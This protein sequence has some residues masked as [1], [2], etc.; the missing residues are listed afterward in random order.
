MDEKIDFTPKDIR[1][2]LEEL[3][4]FIPYF[5]ERVN[6]T[7]KFQYFD[8]EKDQLVDYEGY[9]EK[10]RA[11]KFPDPMYDKTFAGFKHIFIEKIS[12]KLKP[13]L[14]PSLQKPEGEYTPQE[15]FL[16]VLF[17]LRRDIVHERLCTGHTASCMKA[18]VYLKEL[19][20]LQGMLDGKIKTSSDMIEAI[21][22]LHKK[23]GLE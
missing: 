17:E 3:F 8:G 9:D 19:K 21:N 10:N 15:L 13:A 14:R 5:E 4:T 2:E 23:Y 18:G 20:V 11:A 1:K 7:F 16:L 6:G 22:S 12:P